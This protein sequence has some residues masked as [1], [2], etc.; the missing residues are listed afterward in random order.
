[1]P[2]SIAKPGQPKAQ[3]KPIAIPRCVLCT[4]KRSPRPRAQRPVYYVLEAHQGAKVRYT[5]LENLAYTL[6]MGSRKLWHYFLAHTIT[7]L[8]SYPLTLMLRNKDASGRIGKWAMELA[9]FDLI[10]VA[11]TSIKSQALVYFVAEWTPSLRRLRYPRPRHPGQY[12]P[13]APGVPRGKAQ[14]PS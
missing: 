5:E 1:M 2:R 10:F 9:P 7:V 14:Q 13:T 8:T 4:G 11:R 3:L 12:I 6:L